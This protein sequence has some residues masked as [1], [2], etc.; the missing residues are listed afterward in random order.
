MD[1]DGSFE[2]DPS[3]GLPRWIRALV[4]AGLAPDDG[5]QD[6]L[7]KRV[8]TLTTMTTVA[9]I[10]IW[11]IT[12]LALGLYEAA[13]VP[14]AYVF[15]TGF[16]FASFALTNRY[17]LFRNVQLVLLLVFPAVLHWLLGGYVGGSAVV[18]FAA[19][20]PMLSLMVVGR[21]GSVVLMTVFVV[22]VAGLG[23]TDGLIA[24]TAPT[25]PTGVAVGL[26]V[27]N[28]V[29]VVVIVYFPLSFYITAFGRAHDALQAERQ[30]S[31]QLMD[32]LMPAR[33]AA[34]LKAG[35]KVIADQLSGVGVLFA[36]IVG[37]TSVAQ[38]LPAE[39][40]VRRLNRAFTSFDRLCDKFGLVKIKTIGDS[41]MVAAGLSA[42]DPRSVHVLADLALAMREAAHDLTI[43]GESPLQ[44]RFGIDVG[45]VIAGVVG[46]HMLSYDLYGDVVNT[47]NRMASHGTPGRIH[48]TDRVRARCDGEF[49]F[50]NRG[51]IEVKGKG[52]ME[53]FFLEGR[54]GSGP[55]EKAGTQSPPDRL[56]WKS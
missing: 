10:S 42:D 34:R 51:S 32:S 25:V 6:R 4:D 43:D 2:I 17:I 8:L 40:I 28:I 36:D 50:E 49:L 27:L 15:V 39:Q 22:I 45:P 13:L 18:M 12:Y 1:N 35:E 53:T 21:R 26:M 33:I 55:I 38:R 46:E 14:A 29:G 52:H 16:A 37:F 41:Y 30:R 48:V 9:V 7:R 44:L 31:D 19:L 3:E 5:E 24:R 47:A 11:P 23:L 56:H 20:A 54:A